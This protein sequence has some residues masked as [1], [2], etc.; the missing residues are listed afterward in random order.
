[1]MMIMI[2]PNMGLAVNYFIVSYYPNAPGGQSPM[3]DTATIGYLYSIK[4]NLYSNPGYTFN[5]WNSKQ[6]G[7][8]VPYSPGMSIKVSADLILYAQWRSILPE[9]VKITYKANANDSQ[10]DM[11]DPVNKGSSYALKANLYARSGYTF[12]GWNTQASGSGSAFN[13]GQVITANGD[14]TL[15]AKWNLTAPESITILYRAN[16]HDSQADVTDTVIKGSAYALRANPFTRYGYMFTGWN[17]QSNGFGNAFKS[18]QLVTAND[19]N[20]LYAQWKVVVMET[21]SIT[22]KANAND[23]QADVKDTVTK[24]SSFALRA[25]PFTRSGYVFTGWNTKPNASGS[26]YKPG[27]A[28][29]TNTYQILYAM[30]KAAGSAVKKKPK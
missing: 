27:Q 22:Y 18:E 15:Y 7:M 6:D 11:T 24:G 28:F 5:G 25:N 29:T 10:A 14:L 12:T 2:A 8:G 3:I 26:T 13:P 17:T 16:A 1:M 30:W 21:V 19:S 4:F 20:T 23:S 9:R